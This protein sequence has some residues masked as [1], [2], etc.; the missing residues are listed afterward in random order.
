MNFLVEL[1]QNPEIL[2]PAECWIRA[3]FHIASRC[4]L[5]T[6]SNYQLEV[7]TAVSTVCREKTTNELG[8]VLHHYSQGALVLPQGKGVSDI[9]DTMVEGHPRP[10]EYLSKI[11]SSLTTEGF[12]SPFLN[13]SLVIAESFF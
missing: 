9:L 6:P 8:S 7:C 10:L 13:Q 5:L 11:H 1:S 3:A 12:R 4:P 2:F